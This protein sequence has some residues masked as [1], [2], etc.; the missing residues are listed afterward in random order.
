MTLP[1]PQLL[2]DTQ[3]SNVQVYA[4]VDRFK[5][6][7]RVSYGRDVCTVELGADHADKVAGAI[8]HAMRLITTAAIDKTGGHVGPLA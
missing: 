3:K 1:T 4:D 5:V 2:P 6:V 7:L 8:H